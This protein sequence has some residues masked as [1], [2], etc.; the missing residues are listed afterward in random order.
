MPITVAGAARRCQSAL[1]PR[2]GWVF[3]PCPGARGACQHCRMGTGSSFDISL[4][5][6]RAVTGNVSGLLTGAL[7]TALQVEASTLKPAAFSRLGA[8]VAAAGDAV[9]QQLAQTV[10]A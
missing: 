2:D 1:P 9:H 4:P 3:L 7:N 6:V 10:R 8:P 5:D